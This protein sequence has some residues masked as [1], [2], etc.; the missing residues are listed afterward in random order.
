MRRLLTV[1]A[2]LL[3]TAAPGVMV[4]VPAATAAPPTCLVVDTNANRSYTPT[5]PTDNALQDAVNAAASGDTLFVKGT[6]SVVGYATTEISKNL[7]ISGQS[8]SGHQAAT[9]DGGASGAGFGSVLSIDSGV[10]VTLN[11]L[12]IT[13]GGGGI[14]DFGGTVT[15]NNSTISH[16]SATFGGG[17]DDFGGTVTLNNST[18]IYNSAFG[19]G[20]GISVGVG[21][22]T[23]NN[24]TVTG[25]TAAEGGGIFVEESALTLANG[26]TVTYNTAGEGGGIF[27]EGG[28]AT[29]ATG[30]TVTYNTAFAD[31]GGI[32]VE[33]GTLNGATAAPPPGG[34]V[35]NNTPDDIVSF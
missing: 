30:S 19:F 2:V 14:D 29:L 13:D 35:Y 25:N 20:G 6:C 34:N 16:N 33:G 8:A 23:L 11:A 5:S 10:N 7:T 28:T 9:L 24:S 3:G 21:T 15:L 31:G 27:V 22:V 12:I 4:A 26:S 17:I 1:A 32:F 18:V